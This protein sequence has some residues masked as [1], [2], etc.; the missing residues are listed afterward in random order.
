MGPVAT[1]K[2]AFGPGEVGGVDPRG[3]PHEPLVFDEDGLCDVP[4]DSEVYAQTIATLLRDG[5]I[6]AVESKPSRKPKET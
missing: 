2:S 1:F 3:N 5:V 4:H 6:E